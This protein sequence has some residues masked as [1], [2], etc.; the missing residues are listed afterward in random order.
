[1]LY[2]RYH[3]P[4]T[5]YFLQSLGSAPHPPGN[6]QAPVRDYRQGAVTG[7]GAGGWGQRTVC[8]GDLAD[9]TRPDRAEH[10]PP[11]QGEHRVQVQGTGHLPQDVERP[12]GPVMRTGRRSG[13][14]GQNRAVSVGRGLPEQRDER[15]YDRWGRVRR[16]GVLGP[17][18]SASRR[19]CAHVCGVHGWRL[20]QREGFGQAADTGF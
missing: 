17:F 5:V 18:G 12:Q 8:A 3:S 2:I 1:M 15:W 10:L 19:L 9:G 20:A 16:G 11:S 6:I 7:R 13:R 14:Q 4:L